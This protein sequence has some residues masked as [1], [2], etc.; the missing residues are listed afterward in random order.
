[1]AL[2]KG[3]EKLSWT[4]AVSPKEVLP[5]LSPFS[6][7]F[8]FPFLFAYIRGSISWNRLSLSDFG[9]SMFR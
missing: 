1:M 3:L 2:M 8:S 7:S 6:L 9:R 5:F 4:Y